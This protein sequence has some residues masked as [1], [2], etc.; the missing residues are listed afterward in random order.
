MTPPNFQ[1]ASHSTASPVSHEGAGDADGP[2]SANGTSPGLQGSCSPAHP[3]TSASQ[4]SVHH[5]GSG[6]QAPGLL[7]LGPTGYPLSADIHIVTGR[8][9]G[10]QGFNHHDTSVPPA[11][12]GELT[13]RMSFKH[14]IISMPKH[15]TNKLTQ[16]IN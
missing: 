4:M 6:F 1:G 16:L 3:C 12:R 5:R 10:I 15:S 2:R 8:D 7:V 14:Q 13:Q 11:A 9:T